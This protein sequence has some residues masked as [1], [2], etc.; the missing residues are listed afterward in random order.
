LNREN[1][2]GTQPPSSI[3]PQGH[4]SGLD[5][6]T[7]DTFHASQ[8]PQANAIP[9][10][11]SSGKIDPSWLNV[12][13]L[14]PYWRLSIDETSGS[15]TSPT[16]FTVSRQLKYMSYGSIFWYLSKWGTWSTLWEMKVNCP[17]EMSVSGK[18]GFID[19]NVYIF[20]NE[21]QV[22]SATDPGFKNKS[23]TLDLV[24]GDNLIQIVHNSSGGG[25][26]A[27]DIEIDFDWT[28]IKFVPL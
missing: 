11:D 12:Y 22:A 15:R 6:D 23:F 9:V 21:T 17:S 20:L 5:A 10:A 3:S 24:A 7:L 16:D 4:D 1:H 25:G 28:Q 26:T 13:E 19:D 14:V 2:T 18:I 8:I 27:L